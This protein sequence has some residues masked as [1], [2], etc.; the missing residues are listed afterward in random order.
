MKALVVDGYNAI[1]KIP[2]L[3]KLMETD[4][5]GARREITELAKVYQKK[6][7]GVDRVY[8]VFDGSDAYRTGEFPAPE[9]QVFSR[10]GKG[11][12]KII[13]LVSRLS[14]NYHVEVVTDDNFVANNSRA[15]RASVLT[16]SEFISVVRERSGKR[17]TE[18]NSPQKLSPQKA[19]AI[20]EELKKHWN[21]E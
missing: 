12:E 8:V 20:D 11:D 19:T 14:R 3:V 16:V 13:D 18:E 9:H 15:H 2:R 5:R 21:I 7:G 4:L 6:R 10:T 1:Y 17:F